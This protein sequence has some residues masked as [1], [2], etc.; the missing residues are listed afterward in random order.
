MSINLYLLAIDHETKG[1]LSSAFDLINDGTCDG[2]KKK[3]AAALKERPARRSTNAGLKNGVY[4]VPSFVADN[5]GFETIEVKW[6]W[7]RKAQARIPYVTIDGE[8]TPAS[9]PNRRRAVTLVTNGVAVPT[10]ASVEVAEIEDD[11]AI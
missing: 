9:N 6:S 5:V 7:N 10:A 3:I 4:A 8:Y 1:D 2:K 11:L